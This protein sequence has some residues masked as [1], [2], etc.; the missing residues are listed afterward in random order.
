MKQPSKRPAPKKKIIGDEKRYRFFRGLFLFSA[1]L[2]VVCVI[3]LIVLEG[4]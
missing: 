4:K 2:I 3:A 1:A